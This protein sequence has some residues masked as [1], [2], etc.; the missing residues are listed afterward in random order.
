[1]NADT[2]TLFCSEGDVEANDS[3]QRQFSVVWKLDDST[4]SLVRKNFI[5]WRTDV[6]PC[7]ER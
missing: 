6:F 2:L 5:M 3:F 1:M 4:R 7:C